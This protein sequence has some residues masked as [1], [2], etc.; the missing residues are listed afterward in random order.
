MSLIYVQMIVLYI[1]VERISRW[2]NCGDRVK[3]NNR[4]NYG[5]A[6]LLESRPLLQRNY[7]LAT[8]T[9][10]KKGHQT[11]LPSSHPS[12]R[13][14]LRIVQISTPSTVNVAARHLLK[15]LVAKP[16]AEFLK[17]D[18]TR[19]MGE[20]GHDAALFIVELLLPLLIAVVVRLLVVP[21][22]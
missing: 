14:S 11:L 21:V 22:L 16:T 19:L 4:R 7:T 18:E 5:T 10:N 1:A 6:L 20:S 15:N 8:F 17:L 9:K 2:P 3:R 12:Q 13:M